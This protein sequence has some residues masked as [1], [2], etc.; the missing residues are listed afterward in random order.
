VQALEQTIAQMEK[1]L[2]DAQ[3]QLKEKNDELEK[4]AAELGA[5]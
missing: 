2:E 1:K 4:F 3:A 5:L